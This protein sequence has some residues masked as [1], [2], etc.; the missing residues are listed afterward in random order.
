MP[1]A[2]GRWER[3]LWGIPLPVRGKRYTAE[4][5]HVAKRSHSPHM[6]VRWVDQAEEVPQQ[7]SVNVPDRDALATQEHIGAAQRPTEILVEMQE[8]LSVKRARMTE[9]DDNGGTIGATTGAACT[10]EVIGLTRRDIAH[11]YGAQP[12]DVDAKFH[13]SRGTQDITNASLK[14]VLQTAILFG[15]EL[16]AM[17]LRPEA[18]GED[19]RRGILPALA[20]HLRIL[21]KRSL[22]Y[23]L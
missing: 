23:P 14:Q 8:H 7:E 1:V 5:A 21:V 9:R 18:N 19:R 17:L 4:I 13:R 10:L 12:A 22:V 2:I 11:Q 20:H 6:H 3:W 15:R 16:S